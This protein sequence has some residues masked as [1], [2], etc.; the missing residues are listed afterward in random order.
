[1]P[2]LCSGEAYGAK[3]L[4]NIDVLL[5]KFEYRGDEDDHSIS[6]YLDLSIA[7][8]ASKNVFKAA[9]S[10]QSTR[11]SLL[12]QLLISSPLFSQR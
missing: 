9:Q 1:M 11:L 10:H 8:H 3:Q 12:K 2:T 5:F 6:Y 7:R 4:F